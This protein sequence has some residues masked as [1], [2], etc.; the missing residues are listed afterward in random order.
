MFKNREYVLTIY[1]EGSFTRA[2]E[3]LFISQ[4]S[5]SASIKRI[6]EKLGAPIFDRSTTPIALTEIG[7]EYVRC[8]M[9]ID[10]READF[11]RYISDNTELKSGKIRIGGSSFFSSFIIPTLIAEFKSE[12]E[13][14]TFEIFEDSTKNLMTK[15]SL[16]ELDIVIDNKML[17]DESITA[18][19]YATEQILLAVPKGLL[20]GIEAELTAL[21]MTR[22]DIKAGK[23][24]ESRRAPISAFSHLPFILLHNENDT[25]KRADKLFKKHGIEPT[26]LFRLDQQVTAY[27]IS[28]SGL[29]ISFVSDT[30]VKRS[31][32]SSDLL[33]FAIDDE[34]AQRSIYFYRKK[35]RYQ[36]LACRRFIELHTAALAKG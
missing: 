32:A 29:G 21:G 33:Y 10:E 1:K 22:E 8:A 16:G 9:D 28:S 14:I 15:L 4:P 35:N 7:K 19:R 34:I 12:H 24:Y 27:N 31:G 6:E 36:P 26:V 18:E 13:G 11:I 3:K 2:S 5:L 17:T 20:R 25:G 23:H 30:L